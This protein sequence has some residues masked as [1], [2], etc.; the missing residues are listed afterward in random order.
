MNQMGT[1]PLTHK[2]LYNQQSPRQSTHKFP[3]VS[4]TSEDTKGQAYKELRKELEG[5][6]AVKT[7]EVA[8]T[9]FRQVLTS[10]P[11][12]VVMGRPPS[13]S[14]ITP[15]RDSRHQQDGMRQARGE[16][17]GA[18]AYRPGGGRRDGAK[19]AGLNASHPAGLRA[20]LHRAHGQPQHE[21]CRPRGGSCT[22]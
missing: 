16:D 8:N 12:C 21:V 2:Q 20:A 5:S 14:P 10:S 15:R 22:P 17:I 9:M 19:V 3:P 1:L 7:I 11:H 6:I 4:Q 13:R 18:R